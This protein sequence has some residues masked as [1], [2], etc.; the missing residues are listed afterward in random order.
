M[1]GNDV[2]NRILGLINETAYKPMPIDELVMI[3]AED[4]IEK[5]EVKALVQEMFEDGELFINK[6]GKVGSLKSYSM[7]KGRYGFT[8]K[9]FGFV[10]SEKDNSDIYID[11]DD[12]NG[13]FDGDTV[14][15]KITKEPTGRMNKEGVVIKILERANREIVGLFHENNGFGFVIPDNKKFDSDVF[16]PKKYFSGAK[17]NDKVVCKIEVWPD[18]EKKPEG[19]ITEIIGQSGERF[20]EIDSIVRSHGF[21]EEFPEKVIA[22]LEMIENKVK[23][24]EVDGRLDLRE[25]MIY[26]IDGDD[27]KDFDDAISVELL[28]NGNYELGVH[29]ADVTHY[30]KENSPLDREALRR[31]TSVYMVDKVIPML[32]QKL[33]NGICSLNPHVDRLT[34]SCIMEVNPQNAKV[35]RHVILES[36]I[37]SNARLTY[38]EVSEFLENDDKS[39]I[40]NIDD[41]ERTE[42]LFDSLRNAGVLSE[43]LR[44]N[45]FKR[46]AIDFDFPESKIVLNKNGYPIDI[47]PYER[48]VSN[49][50]IEEFM[51][52]ANETIAEHFFW[53]KTPFVYRVHE[54]PDSEK[55][56]IL[57][58]YLYEL[59]IM[60]RI[61]K[62]GI[63]PSDLQRVLDSIEDFEI[64]QAVGSIMLRTLRQ[65][66]YSPE[67]LGHFGLAA[68][69]YCHF[70]SPI[71]R[72]PD[73]QIHR[74]IK[75]QISGKLSNKRITHYENILYG[76]SDQSSVLERKAEMAERDVDDYYKAVFMSD[77]VGDEFEGHI[78]GITNFGIFV[79]LSNGVEGMISLESLP[80]YYIYNERSKTLVGETT[81]KV[82]K[83]GQKHKVKLIKV[84]V[85]TRKIDFSFIQE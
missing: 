81:K 50:L 21:Q 67:C 46:G 36:V 64:K 32:P 52:L 18:D 5:S 56:T 55:V 23:P 49:K 83:I 13:A 4:K 1:L 3:F 37:R 80:D 73:L 34:L 42:E 7:V 61:S 66:R 29:I 20:V 53:L 68:T 47:S 40:E 17:N 54:L 41:P 38:H 10:T 62:G 33:S 59:D 65:A 82:Y 78:S 57:K 44:K 43:L 15:V 26:T 39:L 25:K 58:E 19:I 84:E 14:L 6:K 30:V 8:R 2:K 24:N 31:G 11:S 60:L 76:V 22:Q 12:R 63:R 71:R 51:L 74:I 27:S 9:T 75:E 35:V 85:E 16:I 28:D 45:R 69:Y 77:K 79:E 72:Y 70:T 48:R